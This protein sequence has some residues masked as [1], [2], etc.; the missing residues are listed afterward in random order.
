MVWLAIM[1]MM[2][3]ISPPPAS[4]T[5]RMRTVPLRDIAYHA[6]STMRASDGIPMSRTYHS[7]KAPRT[8]YSTLRAAAAM[9]TTAAPRRAAEGA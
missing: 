8:T 9:A 7:S 3:A 1:T 6:P 4:A 5:A 2:N